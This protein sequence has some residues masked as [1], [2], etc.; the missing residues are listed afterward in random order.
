MAKYADLD[1]KED[2]VE[3]LAQASQESRL[4]NIID[5]KLVHYSSESLLL[6][7]VSIRNSL[8]QFSKKNSEFNQL[9]DQKNNQQNKNCENIKVRDRF[10]KV[11]EA[12]DN[13]P[14]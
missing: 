6:F 10:N 8:I 11:E 3:W 7:F 9:D 14:S 2:L 5:Q 4:H 12:M 1:S 13:I